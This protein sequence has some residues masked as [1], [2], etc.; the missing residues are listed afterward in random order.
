MANTSKSTELSLRPD[1]EVLYRYFLLAELLGDSPQD[2]VGLVWTQSVGVWR[3]QNVCSGDSLHME[4]G[5]SQ[6]SLSLQ[7]SVQCQ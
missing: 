4:A 1:K 6:L 5:E 2:K 7:K 3:E